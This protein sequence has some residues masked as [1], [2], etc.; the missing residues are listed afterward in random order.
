MTLP[1]YLLSCPLCNGQCAVWKHENGNCHVTYSYS[2][3]C[4]NEDDCGCSTGEF[5]TAEEV[6]EVWHRNPHG[7]IKFPMK[8]VNF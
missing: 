1:D 8:T 4:E 3:E 7:R 6:I 2:I 5:D